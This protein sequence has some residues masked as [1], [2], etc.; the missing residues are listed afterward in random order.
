MSSIPNS[1][2]RTST[3]EIDWNGRG[4]TVRSTTITMNVPPSRHGHVND[5]TSP[6]DFR[7]T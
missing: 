5:V 3:S 7:S 6:G 1:D 4:A 2:E